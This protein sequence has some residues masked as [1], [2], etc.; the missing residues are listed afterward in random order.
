MQT[1]ADKTHA[2]ILAIRPLRPGETDVIEA[3][4]ERL[5][6]HSRAMRFGGPKPLLSE[7]ELAVLADITPRHHA[8]VG[9]VDGDSAPAGIARLVVERS[10]RTTAEVACA[11]ADVYQGRGVGTA[12]MR[13]L[14]ADA[15]AAGVQRLHATILGDNRRAVGVLRKVAAIEEIRFDGGDIDVTASIVTLPGRGLRAA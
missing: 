4:F 13:A 11:I 12:L 5:G 7:P 8:L 14:V 1:R 10:D 9:F 6:P 2:G 3:V 15:R